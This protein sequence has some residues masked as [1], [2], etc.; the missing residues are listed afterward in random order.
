MMCRLHS[1]Q[2]SY[3]TT[4]D[5]GHHRGNDKNARKHKKQEVITRL[6]GTDKAAYLARKHMQQKT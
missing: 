5:P 4:P 2:K 3:N 6:Q 1:N